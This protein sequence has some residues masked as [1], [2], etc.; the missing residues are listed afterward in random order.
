MNSPE[1]PWKPKP[2]AAEP[3]T[4]TQYLKDVTELP[5]SGGKLI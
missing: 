3:T 2:A 5:M 1:L 4:G